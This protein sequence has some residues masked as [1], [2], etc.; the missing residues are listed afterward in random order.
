MGGTR[1]GPSKEGQD[2]SCRG[3][4][5]PSQVGSVPAEGFV[6]DSPQERGVPK[7]PLI[8]PPIRLRRTPQ[9]EWGSGG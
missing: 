7:F 1:V 5:E 8:L 2:F 9:E 4:A 6:V 3:P